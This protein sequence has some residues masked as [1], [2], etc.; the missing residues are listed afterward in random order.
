MN[1]ALSDIVP[2]RILLVR[3]G[4]VR[5]GLMTIPLA[6]DAK[7]LWP[8]SRL[9]WV[10]DGEVGDILDNHSQID[11]VI[12]VERNW[13]RQP[14]T[15]L[16]LRRKLTEQKFDIVLDPQSAFKS[17]VIGWLSGCPIRI[18]LERPFVREFSSLLLTHQIK[19][20]SR[21]RVDLYRELLTPWSDVVA[22][23]ANFGL[24]DYEAANRE[25]TAKVSSLFEH[26]HKWCVIYPGAIW[27]TAI[28][29]I[30]R[31]SQIANY[32]HTSLKMQS[33]IV[34]S[35]PQERL[36]AQVIAEQCRQAAVVA[37]ELHLYELIQLCRQ[38]Q[39]IITGDSDFLQIASAT[40]APCISLHGPTWAD[41]YGPYH[42][43]KYAIQSPFPLNRRRR[44]RRGSNIPMQTI[45]VEEVMF[46]TQRLIS[47]QTRTKSNVA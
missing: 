16:P 43:I 19:P 17:A 30:E 47:S 28:W 38:T 5:D 1:R 26:S 20:T 36:V 41:E 32:I 25:V 12:R 31:F 2:S 4:A 10:V 21:H 29:P 11:E 39:F 46:N 7:K 15:W 23:Q 37:P 8:K 44:M 22:G 27:P 18:G 40:N 9:S 6:V 24:P 42:F 3:L 35:G 14:Q 45:E 34:W 13:I 33:L